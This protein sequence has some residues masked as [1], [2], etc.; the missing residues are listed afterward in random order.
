MTDAEQRERERLERGVERRQRQREGG[1]ERSLAENMALVGALGWLVVVPTL[2]GTFV[3]RWLDRRFDAGLT[4]TG[5]LL[6]LGLVLGC[7][8]AWKRMHER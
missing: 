4:W 3:G 5:A 6:S 2:L 8:L 7:W 1:G